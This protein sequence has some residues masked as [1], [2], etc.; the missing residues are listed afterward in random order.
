MSNPQVTRPVVSRRR[1]YEVGPLT[2]ATKGALIAECGRLLAIA[3]VTGTY[4]ITG[5]S[6]DFV[7]ALFEMHNSYP[8]KTKGRTV[9]KL[10]VKNSPTYSSKCFWYRLDHDKTTDSEFSY[11]KCL[12]GSGAINKTVARQAIECQ[13]EKKRMEVYAE[14]RDL[15][16][17]GMFRSEATGRVFNLC[18]MHIDHKETRFVNIFYSFFNDSTPTVRDG[19]QSTVNV[20]AERLSYSRQGSAEQTW[21]DDDLKR[22][23]CAHHAQKARLLAV[24]STENCGGDSIQPV[25][26]TTSS[27]VQMLSPQPT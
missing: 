17:K 9:T 18:G 26:A 2:F 8:L 24:S 23:W 13:I 7:R 15:Y 3:A 1:S 22:R 4:G 10:W 12:I 5:R 19:R 14:Q 16:E 27:M 25:S 6:F 11:R 21:Y 20:F